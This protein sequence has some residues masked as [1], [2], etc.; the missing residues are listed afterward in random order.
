MRR[1]RHPVIGQSGDVHGGCRRTAALIGT[2]LLAVGLAACGD[3]SGGAENAK[4][5]LKGAGSSLVDPMVQEWSDELRDRSGIDLVY[6]PIGSGGGIQAITTRTVDF[7]ASDAPLT[8]EQADSCDGCILVPWALSATG[9]SYN[10]PE[11]GD[12]LRLSGPVIADIF[13]GKITNWSDPRITKL[14]PGKKLPSQPIQPIYRSEGSGDTFAFT[15][16]L[17]EVS[18]GW[19][20]KVGA[21][22]SVNFPNG[23]GGKGNAGVAGVMSRTPGALGYMGVA[24]AV[25]NKFGLAAIQ[26]AAGQ[27]VAPDLPGITAAAEAMGTPGPDNSIPI[28]DPPA[29]AKGA[30]PIS[31]FTYA[32]VPKDAPKASELKELLEYAIGPGQDVAERF[33]FAK[34]P[35]RVVALAKETIATIGR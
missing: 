33:V 3:S 14:N 19:K 1:L 29:S 9:V 26:N 32:I 15:S 24:Y 17:S 10:L 27:F 4:G 12:D 23:A 30:Y 16:Y 25:R 35:E 11:A 31:T 5:S 2:V 28:V 18:S 21:G 13:L 20:E 22:T 34:L 6:T 7:G 8:P